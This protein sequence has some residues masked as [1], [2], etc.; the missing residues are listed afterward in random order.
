MTPD[1]RP[2]E[3]QLRTQRG[4]FNL[5][6]LDPP[7]SEGRRSF[8]VDKWMARMSRKHAEWESRNFWRKDWV[9]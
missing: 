5:D 4:P 2:R 1:D 3:E 7:D 8:N 6:D 9:K